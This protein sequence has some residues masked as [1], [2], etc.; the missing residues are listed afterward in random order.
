M[1]LFDECG[2][3]APADFAAW[4]VHTC[5]GILTPLRIVSII[6]PRPDINL[7]FVVKMRAAAYF[8]LSRRT[9]IKDRGHPPPY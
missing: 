5:F 8:L 1:A 6:C 4:F 2:I 9:A 3:G 7:G